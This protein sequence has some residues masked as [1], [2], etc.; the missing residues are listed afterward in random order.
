M[1]SKP[2]ITGEMRTSIEAELIGAFKTDLINGPAGMELV[3][4]EQKFKFVREELQT[5]SPETLHGALPYVLI[6]FLRFGMPTA[7]D[8][9]CLGCVVSFLNIK[10]HPY[11]D[12][13]ESYRWEE[14]RRI[15]QWREKAVSRFS[16]RQVR[17]IRLWLEAV[18]D[19]GIFL[20]D[21]VD[22]DQL[23]YAIAY[24]SGGEKGS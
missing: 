2:W 1:D 5:Y 17:A 8:V 15:S 16:V 7:W 24:W 14:M 18:R 12:P 6:G 20:P 4:D 19:S 21:W 23:G 22:S 11:D 3:V 10:L 9:S 13:D